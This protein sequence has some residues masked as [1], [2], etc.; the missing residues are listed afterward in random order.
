MSRR[1][2]DCR[3]SSLYFL[4]VVI[5]LGALAG[6][7]RTFAAEAAAPACSDCHDVTTTMSASVHGQAGLECTSCHT[8]LAGVEEF[9]HAKPAPV[10]CKSCHDV[11]VSPEHPP[12]CADCHGNHSVTRASALTSRDLGARL[13]AM[14]GSCHAPIAADYAASVHGRAL[15]AGNPNVPTCL[16]CHGGHA[17]KMNKD[18]GSPVSS[19]SQASTCAGCHD[20]NEVAAKYGMPKARMQTF[21][22][23]FHGLANAYGDKEVA[24]CATCHGVHRI[25]PS[26][27][28]N[29]T[30]AA[31]NL[32]ATCGRCHAQAGRNF[33]V[34]KVHLLDRWEDNPFTYV[35]RRF[36]QSAIATMMTIFVLFMAAD[37]G[38]RRRRRR[39][40]GGSRS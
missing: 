20:D 23:S 1:G 6:A 11:P 21:R 30:I 16:T 5:F 38:Y 39:R 14:C 12:A 7:S 4:N 28:P 17:I 40:D 34:G 10:D 8:G 24:N 26:T 9:P 25:L 13:S 36:Y 31:A 3:P 32:P 15:N 35:A 29:S 18:P 22:D 37:F 27:D 2:C 33:A 19:L